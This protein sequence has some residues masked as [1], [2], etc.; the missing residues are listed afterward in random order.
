MCEAI[1]T[2]LSKPLTSCPTFL[3]NSYRF[4]GAAILILMFS[5]L[6]VVPSDVVILP[7]I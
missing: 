4:K 7:G 3:I 1:L 2:P 5:G 6:I